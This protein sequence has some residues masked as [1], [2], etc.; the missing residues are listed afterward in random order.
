MR[1]LISVGI[2]VFHH[3]QKSELSEHGYGFDGKIIFQKITNSVGSICMTLFIIAS[4]DSK[5]YVKVM[6]HHRD[7]QSCRIQIWE[8]SMLE[9]YGAMPLK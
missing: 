3:S 4:I 1:A 9:I 7:P 6:M 8:I 2:T 5:V